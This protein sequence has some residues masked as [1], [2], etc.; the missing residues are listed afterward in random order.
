MDQQFIIVEP[1]NSKEDCSMVCVNMYPTLTYT[2]LCTFRYQTV[3]W[4]CPRISY[5]AADSG[6]WK[7]CCDLL[8]LSVGCPVPL[9][10][11]TPLK[12]S[13]FTC[14]VVFFVCFLVGLCLLRLSFFFC[15]IFIF[16]LVQKFIYDM[17]GVLVM[18]WLVN[19]EKV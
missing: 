6:Q 11:V 7:P 13:F 14:K 12:E 19:F 2:A 3:E 18:N 10:T 15:V 16:F 4:T 5:C 9:W 1:W 17:I 8:D